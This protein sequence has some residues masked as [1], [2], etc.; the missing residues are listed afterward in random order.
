MKERSEESPEHPVVVACGQCHGP[1]DE[2]PS[3]PVDARKPCPACGSNTR[4]FKVHFESKVVVHSTLSM[5]GR[6]AGGK[7][8]FI[9]A[10]VGDDLFKE[11]GEW[12][13]IEQVVDRR[14]NRYRKRI[15]D[16]RTGKVLRNTDEP[17]TQHQGYGSAKKGK[18]PKKPS[19]GG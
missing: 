1:I 5:E 11:T 4:L 8:P 18:K 13:Q 9:E 19:G 15:V 7:R 10:K 6:E 3:T 17:L 14:S 2:K 16:P 12:N